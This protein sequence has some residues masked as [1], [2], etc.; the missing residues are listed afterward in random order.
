MGGAPSVSA[1]PPPSAG[2]E[3]TSALQ[4]YAGGA[5][6]NAAKH[7]AR[8][9]TDVLRLELVG[10]PVRVSEIDPGMVDTIT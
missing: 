1:P 2:E 4:A 6:Y 5:G 9:V 10:R 8:A 3:F 7:A